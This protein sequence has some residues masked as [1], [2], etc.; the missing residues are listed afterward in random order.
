MKRSLTVVCAVV[1]FSVGGVAQVS[2]DP[3]D[4][5]LTDEDCPQQF[6]C[7]TVQMPCAA[8]P[9]A[10]ECPACEDDSDEAREGASPSAGGDCGCVCPPCEVMEC[11][12]VSYRVCEWQPIECENDSGCPDGYECVLSESCSG[13]G[14]ACPVCYCDPDSEEPCDC[15]DIVCDCGDISEPEC[16]V[17]GGWCLPMQVECDSDSDCREG[18]VCVGSGSDSVCGCSDCLCPACPPEQECEPCECEPCECDD[19][20]YPETKYCLPD[21]WED[22]IGF[23]GGEPVW[24]SLNDGQYTNAPDGSDV[25]TGGETGTRDENPIE[26]AAGACS[27]GGNMPFPWIPSLFLLVIFAVRR[28][29]VR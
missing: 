23:E 26:P 17:D 6:S 7:V 12:E 22:Y 21:E 28:R 11:D 4:Q 19:I 14:C 25:L 9:C 8:V 15:P 24:E 18:F 2:S 1:F 27:T 3:V 16:V 29:V 20:E 10:C 5:C 13:Y